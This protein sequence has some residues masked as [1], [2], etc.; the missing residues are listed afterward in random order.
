MRLARLTAASLI[1]DRHGLLSAS[2]RDWI[3]ASSSSG[4]R[5]VTRVDVFWLT[6]HLA[7]EKWKVTPARR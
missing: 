3:A 1:H 6:P 7:D 2:A 4:M 5:M